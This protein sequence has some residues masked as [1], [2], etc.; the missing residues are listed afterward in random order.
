MRGRNRSTAE[1]LTGL[2]TLL[3]HLTDGSASVAGDSD[4]A[5]SHCCLR[6]IDGVHQ[7]NEAEEDGLVDTHFAD[8]D[9]VDECLEECSSSVVELEQCYE[10]QWWY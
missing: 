10:M 7:A 5:L 1:G 2:A 6:G 4:G 9:E 8:G 3:C